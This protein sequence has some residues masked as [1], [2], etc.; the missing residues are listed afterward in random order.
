MRI[1]PPLIATL[2]VAAAP[3]TA[4]PWS[5]PGT[6]PTSIGN[7]PVLAVGATGPQA[8]FWNNYTGG[9]VNGLPGPGGQI[10]TSVSTLGPGLVPTPPQTVTPAFSIAGFGNIGDAGFGGSGV[11]LPAASVS[12][13][14]GPLTGPL[15]VHKLTAPIRGIATNAAGDVAVV[16]E[17]CATKVSSCHPAAPSLVR[18][19]RG[20]AFS[21]P[22]ALGP[23]GHAYGAAVAIDPRGRVLV[24]WDRNGSVYARFVSTT[25][26]LGATQRL[27]ADTGLSRL[28]AV[29]PGDGRAAVAWTTQNIDEGDATSPFTARIALAD[30]TGRFGRAK[31]LDTVPVTGSGR[32]VPYQGLAITLPARQPGLATW[33]GYVGGHYVVAAAPIAG[34]TVGAAT[35]VSDPTVDTVLADAAEGSRGEAVILVLPGRA[36]EDPPLPAG[37][38]GLDAVTRPAAG[39]PFAGLEPIV[40]GP[41][42]IDGATVSIA[43]ASG[44]AFATWRDVDGPVGWSV[45]PSIG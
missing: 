33:T 41:A 20:H 19:R 17:V 23:K 16:T 5:A 27:G 6:F 7:S 3:A 12:V 28:Q 42:F 25:G 13:A 14:T 45:R 11:V 29:L 22:I 10:S 43:A 26:K 37:P 38:G 24:A 21:R 30:S 1:L 8:V 4:A 35:V 32:Y 9:I 40:P 39:Q 31:L 36:G 2:L 18:K 34:A 44:G 15:A